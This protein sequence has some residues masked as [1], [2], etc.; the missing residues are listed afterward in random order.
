[1]EQ[2]DLNAQVDYRPNNRVMDCKRCQTIHP[3]ANGS[4]FD[5]NSPFMM[6]RIQNTGNT[7]IDPDKTR[8]NFK[9]AAKGVAGNGSVG[10]A[11]A[12]T[13]E[14]LNF[15]G[16]EIT[17]A[18]NDFSIALSAAGVSGMIRRIELRVGGSTIENIDSYADI[19]RLFQV[20]QV[21]QSTVQGFMSLTEGL[22]SDPTGIGFDGNT[23]PGN[24]PFV[25]TRGTSFAGANIDS[26]GVYLNTTVGQPPPEAGFHVFDASFP[27]LSAVLGAGCGKYFPLC[28]LRSPL[29]VYFYLESDV[30]KV[31]M[32]K[33]N[34]NA[35]A[36]SGN[37]WTKSQAAYTACNYQITDANLELGLVVF[38]E[39]SMDLIR[40]QIDDTMKIQWSGNQVH[41][42]TDVTS[43]IKGNTEIIVPGCNY[44]NLK[45]IFMVQKNNAPNGT[46]DPS[47][48]EGFGLKSLQY[49]IEGRL[50]PKVAMGSENDSPGSI[51][52]HASVFAR[53]LMGAINRTSADLQSGSIQRSPNFNN[54]N[55]PGTGFGFNPMG[56]LGNTPSTA[57]NQSQE[58][59]AYFTQSV[60]TTTTLPPSGDTVGFAELCR[61]ATGYSFCDFSDPMLYRQARGVDTSRSFVTM[62]LSRYAGGANYVTPIKLVHIPLFEVS[63]VLDLQTGI[64]VTEV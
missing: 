32:A 36:N 49:S 5:K 11:S 16:T 43:Y 21:K 56:G 39:D 51:V 59:Q 12:T 6:F 55:T 42:I 3:P 26:P 9:Y 13:V 48:L 25:V 24:A 20:T 8:L 34:L 15:T 60:N 62:R 22:M 17:N 7:F 35:N 44:R 33:G 47:G 27:I 53:Y 54:P 45:S 40:S 18:A 41:G 63:Y 23:V 61:F 10:T 4:T 1:M 37:S 31:I 52:A 46:F 2:V 30:T 50:Y 28:L 29:E 58:F 14:C 64:L 57:V 19:V 38:G